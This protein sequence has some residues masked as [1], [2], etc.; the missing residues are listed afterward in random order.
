MFA[1]TKLWK[2]IDSF[3][4]IRSSGALEFKV[5]AFVILCCSVPINNH[6]FKGFQNVDRTEFC[7]LLGW[8][9]PC[10]LLV[11]GNEINQWWSFHY[12]LASSCTSLSLVIQMNGKWGL[13]LIWFFLFSVFIFLVFVFQANEVHGSAHG[14]LFLCY[15]EINHLAAKKYQTTSTLKMDD[16]PTTFHATSLNE[17]AIK[18]YCF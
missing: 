9:F 12:M 16:M 11:F 8:S 14:K 7:I 15:T 1:L 5:S 10:P 4:D 6:L 3:K 17:C 18:Q 2:C 13:D